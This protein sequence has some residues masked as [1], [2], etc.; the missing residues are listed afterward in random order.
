M[1][2][3]KGRNELYSRMRSFRFAFAG[4]WY[5]IRTQHNA[6][7]HAVISIAVAG[8]ALWLRLSRLEWAVLILTMMAVWMAEF[9]NTA[10]EAVVDMIA[11]EYHPLAK[12]A[13][14]VAAAAVLVGAVGAVLIGLLL[15]GMP[16]LQRL[17]G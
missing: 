4:W 1:M 14:D 12:V 3:N 9:M 16:L 8:L 15:M 10:I 7:I 11:P 17:F 5:V 13:K 2:G 6:W